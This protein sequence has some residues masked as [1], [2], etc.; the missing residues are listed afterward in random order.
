MAIEDKQSYEIEAATERRELQVAIRAP[1]AV[2]FASAAEHKELAIP[3]AP[4]GITH[5]DRWATPTGDGTLEVVRPPHGI[6][7]GA[8]PTN[9]ITRWHLAPA[10][11][12]V[13][14]VSS[15][16]A[17]L[18]R[19]MHPD[20]YKEI[21]DTHTVTTT[22]AKCKFMDLACPLVADDHSVPKKVKL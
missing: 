2:E 7:L 12:S 19:P 21:C 1:A 22:D 20:R 5:T 17:A 4:G 11:D 18:D 9:A 3:P 16:V 10:D 8:L 15:V 13:L 6:N 14:A